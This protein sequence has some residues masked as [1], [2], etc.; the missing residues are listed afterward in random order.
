MIGWTMMHR[1]AM[2]R[3]PEEA[4]SHRRSSPNEKLGRS[5]GQSRKP[6][7]L[8]CCQRQTKGTLSS[9]RKSAI[10]KPMGHLGPPSSLIC[11]RFDGWTC[12]T[13]PPLLMDVMIAAAD[14][15]CTLIPMSTC[16]IELSRR[17]PFFSKRRSE[18]H[19]FKVTACG[20]I[21]G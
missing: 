19:S 17:M 2:T 10:A 18:D 16:I 15:A 13:T 12:L 4:K 3:E 11:S 8:F 20:C 5:S 21:D 14:I 1:H 7:E 9:L 6:F